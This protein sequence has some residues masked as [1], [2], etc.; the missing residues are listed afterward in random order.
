MKVLQG[1]FLEGEKVTVEID[2][3]QYT[4]RVHYRMDCGLYIIV[5]KYRYFEYEVE[6]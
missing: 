2:N 1:N 5:N 3:K 6:Y 4:R